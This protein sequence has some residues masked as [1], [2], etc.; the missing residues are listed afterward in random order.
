MTLIKITMPSI[1]SSYIHALVEFDITSRN[2][3][4]NFSSSLFDYFKDIE[5]NEF[6]RILNF[7]V[8]T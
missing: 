6:E 2:G 4:I 1:G 7:L 5:I 8:L 3:K